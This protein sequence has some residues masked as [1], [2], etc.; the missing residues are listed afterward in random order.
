M[1]VRLAAGARRRSRIG[2]ASVVKG[3]TRFAL[4]DWLSG[5]Q[6]IAARRASGL[7][8]KGN[9]ALHEVLGGKARTD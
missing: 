9:W 4:L 5:Q 3:S 1:S 2:Q 8:S 7:V 6:R